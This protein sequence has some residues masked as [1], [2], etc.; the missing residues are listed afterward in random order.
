MGGDINNLE[1][2]QICATFPDLVNVVATPTRGNR[3]LDVI[4]TNL[5]QSYDKAV[6]LPP[7][8]PDVVGNGVPSDHSVAI[9]RPNVDK[10]SRTGFSRKEVRTRRVVLTSS[11]ALLGMFLATFDWSG[12]YSLPGV[13][14]KLLYMNEVLFAAQDHFCPLETFTVRL[15]KH[16]H[17]SARLAKLSK[18]KSEEFR[19]HRYSSRFK[20]LKEECRQELQRIK[21]RRIQDAVND[22]DGSN[23]WLGR[24]EQLLDPNGNSN[25]RGGVLPEHLAAGLSRQQ[26]A[27]DYA[28]HISRI[29]RDYVPLTR[30]VLPDRVVHALSNAVCQ[31]HPSIDSRGL[32]DPMWKKDYWWS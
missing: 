13:D 27:E 22:G 30:A 26:Q 8:Q 23:S 7:I 5:H 9:A 4:V 28:A 3:I 24:L 32:R 19:K 31:G 17:V 2:D 16:P 18:L 12:L 1:C 20:D 10:G 11:L 25:K 14:S 15:G 29:S 21:Q 6:I